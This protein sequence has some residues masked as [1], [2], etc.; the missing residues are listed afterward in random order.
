MPSEDRVTFRQFCRDLDDAL[1]DRQVEEVVL[2]H[3]WQPA[4]EHYQ[5][6]ETVRSTRRYHMQVRGWSDNGYHVM[7][8]PT[9]DIFLCRP[10]RRAGCHVAG[11]NAHTVGV[12][13]IANFDQDDPSEYAG[14]A[15]GHRVVAALLAHFDLSPTAIRFHREFAA[16]TCP[17]M[18]LSIADFRRLVGEADY[19]PHAGAWQCKHCGQWQQRERPDAADGAE[20]VT[21]GPGA[22]AH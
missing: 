20:V 18:K 1:V 21:E 11:R 12:A 17:G 5:G 6:I 8:A 22:N 9:G 13:F 10:L 4:A 19:E 14:L 16:K 3:T 15:T 2:H 7:L